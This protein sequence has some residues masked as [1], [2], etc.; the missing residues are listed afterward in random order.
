M[1]KLAIIDFAGPIADESKRF[2]LARTPGAG[3]NW[4]VFFDPQHLHTDTLVEGADTAINIL[5]AH[6]YTVVLM[7]S[8]PEAM[9]HAT[10]VWC[11]QHQISF[12]LCAASLAMKPPAAQWMKTMQLKAIMVQMLAGV[13]AASSVVVVEDEAPNLAEILTYETSYHLRGFSSLADCIA[14]LTPDLHADDEASP[15]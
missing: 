15:F 4:Q 10:E 8:R 5:R 7:T 9:R 6:D 12:G 13:C 2:D 3:M 14:W 1:N 11:Q